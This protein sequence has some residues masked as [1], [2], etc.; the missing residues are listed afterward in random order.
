MYLLAV[1]GYSRNNVWGRLV[2]RHCTAYIR[3]IYEYHRAVKG[4]FILE[5][6]ETALVR[7]L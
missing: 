1:Q 7:W 4:T 5:P 3:L 6:A 2:L